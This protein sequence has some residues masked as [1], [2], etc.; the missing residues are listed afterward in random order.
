MGKSTAEV[1]PMG[2]QVSLMAETIQLI[3]K[4]SFMGTKITKDQVRIMVHLTNL[5]KNDTIV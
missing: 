4:K 2:I 1:I 5:K 3:K